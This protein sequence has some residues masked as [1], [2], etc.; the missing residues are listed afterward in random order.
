MALS[1]QARSFFK[2]KSVLVTGGCGSIGGQVVEEILKL[3]PKVVRVFS[4]DEGKHFDMQERLG[5]RKDIRYLV[6]DVRDRRRLNTAMKGIDVVFHAAAMK[7]VPACEYNPFEAVQTNVIGTQ[8]VIQ[9]AA[10]RELPHLVAIST[11]KAMTP[12]NTMGASKLLAEKLVASA[13]AWNPKTTMSCVR[14][15][16]VVGSRGSVVPA[17]IRSIVTQREVRI[18]EPDMTRFMMT[19]QD[20]VHLT[21]NSCVDAEGGEIFIFKMPSL[22]LNDLV[23]VVIEET[24]RREKMSPT[25]I[26]RVIIGIR[27]GEK[28][29]EGLFSE[30]ELSRTEERR[31]TFV[32]HSMDEFLRRER[33]GWGDVDTAQLLSDKCKLLNKDEIKQLL[34]RAHV[35]DHIRRVV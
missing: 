26:K 4:R 16:N 28:M 33:K 35:W 8:N 22:K 17:M 29:H 5:N 21:L 2:G 12:V 24:C 27:P 7:H 31:D 32:V 13:D 11:D 23:D 14:F 20:A 30:E 10:E 18:T 3:E 1:E 19:I 25:M 9:M 15:G 6:G 34:D